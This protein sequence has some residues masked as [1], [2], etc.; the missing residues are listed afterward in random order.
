APHA[1]HAH[2]RGLNR[3]RRR[4]GRVWVRPH[5]AETLLGEL[6]DL[7]PRLRG[8]CAREPARFDGVWDERLVGGYCGRECTGGYGP[9]PRFLPRGG[10]GEEVAHEVKE[11]RR[12]EGEGVEAI[13][14]SP[15][16]GYQSA[17]VLDV[18]VAF[19]GAHHQAPGE[20]EHARDEGHHPRLP[21]GE[22][23]EP[24]EPAAEHGS[25][26]HAADETFPGLVRAHRRCDRVAAE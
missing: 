8:A 10:S 19:D 12:C 24:G 5:R 7:L 13:H 20:A 6:H 23:G 15:V 26:E 17:E 4:P 21:W 1:D 22:R 3:S 2:R 16:P 11:D 9:M 25:G 14:H 18:T